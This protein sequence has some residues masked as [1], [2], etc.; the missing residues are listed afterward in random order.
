M[1]CYFAS[2]FL[3]R[4]LEHSGL[5]TA[6]CAPTS[7]TKTFLGKVNSG[8][9]QYLW[10]LSPCWACFFYFFFVLSVFLFLSL[11]LS[12]CLSLSISISLSLL[13]LFLFIFF[14]TWKNYEASNK[15]VSFKKQLRV[16]KKLH[17]SKKNCVTVLFE[18]S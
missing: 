5:G 2:R 4:R 9:F 16:S 14:F 7:V 3:P 11:S 12:L 8:A 18:A 1:D 15:T 10:L 6:S 17:A 13:C